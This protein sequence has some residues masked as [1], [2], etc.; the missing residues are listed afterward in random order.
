MQVINTIAGIRTL[1]EE[2]RREGGIIGFVPTMG[3]FH[4]GHLSLMRRAKEECG[5]VVVSIFVNPLQFGPREDFASYPRDF[6]RDVAMAE[7]AGADIIFAPDV[8]EMYPPHFYTTVNVEKITE[9]LCGRSRPG[10]FRG[11]ATV[12]TK[13]FNIVRPHRAYFGQKDAQQVLV[14]KRLAEDLNMDLNIVNA[15]LVRESDGLAMS[16]R[17]VYLSPEDRQAA[18][19][20]YRSL[21]EAER[22]VSEGILEGARLEELVR[23]IISREP[24]A[25]I[26]YVEVLSLPDLEP[27]AKISGQALVAVAV[28]FGNTR[29][30][31]NTIVEE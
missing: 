6:D 17:N 9:P 3:Y 29:L 11:V 8:A 28:R 2:V 13:L 12:V 23:A 26:D 18:T 1:V 16:S 4:E 25:A 19:V 20:L 5:L 10:H 14:I 22:A 24:R 7:E 30:I 27:C 15:P 21:Q 31:D